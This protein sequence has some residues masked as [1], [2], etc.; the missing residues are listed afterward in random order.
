MKT[1]SLEGKKGLIFGI[2]NSS[3]L[4]YG[5]AKAFCDL[6]AELAIT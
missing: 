5:C 6:G 4:T 1:I 3:S 2:A